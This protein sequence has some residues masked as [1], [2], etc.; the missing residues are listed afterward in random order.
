MPLVALLESAE[1]SNGAD[2][3]GTVFFE[4]AV[5]EQ[6]LRS[7]GGIFKLMGHCQ[8]ANP[9]T[10]EDMTTFFLGFIHTHQRCGKRF[11]IRR[12]HTFH[13]RVK[14]QGVAPGAT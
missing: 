6:L 11:A 7:P 2:S 12:R 4:T 8:Q 9:T 3:H 5:I 1:L 13:T 14:C 10:I